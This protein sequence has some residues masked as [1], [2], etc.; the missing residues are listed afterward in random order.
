MCE[1][2][3]RSVLGPK[4]LFTPSERGRHPAWM[5]HIDLYLYHSHQA[6]LVVLPLAD[7]SHTHFPSAT[8]SLDVNRA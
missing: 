7:G 6:V 5:G 1:N 2:D 8:L 4:G 3:A